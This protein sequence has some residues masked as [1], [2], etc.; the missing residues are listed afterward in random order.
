MV[1]LEEFAESLSG[2]TLEEDYSV[3]SLIE[4]I[5]TYL[6]LLEKENR[7]IWLAYYWAVEGVPQ[8]AARMGMTK[9]AVT[10]RLSRTKKGMWDYLKKEELL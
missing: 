3:Q 9:S 2:R 5:N 8:I 10:T 7:L 4:G 6:G 1:A